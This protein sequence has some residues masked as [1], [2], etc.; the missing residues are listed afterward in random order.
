MADL[1]TY[2]RQSPPTNEAMTQLLAVW[3]VKLRPPS[4]ESPPAELATED[5]ARRL[6]ETLNSLGVRHAG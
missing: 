6:A 5:D 2:W 1:D 3:G 4:Q